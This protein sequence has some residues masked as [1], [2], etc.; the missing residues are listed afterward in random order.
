MKRRGQNNILPSVHYTDIYFTFETMECQGKIRKKVS[1]CSKKFHRQKVPLTIILPRD[2]IS[3]R[4][5]ATGN[6][7]NL[8]INAGM[9]ELGSDGSAACGGYSDLSEWQWSVCNAAAPSERRTPGTTTG[10]SW[11]NFTCLG[12]LVIEVTAYYEIATGA[13]HPRND[14]RFGSLIGHINNHLWVIFMI[15]KEAFYRLL[16]QKPLILDG[17]TGSNLQKA[18]MPRGCCTEQW[19]LEHPDALIAL[20]RRYVQSGSQVI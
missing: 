5:T 4:H 17:A 14:T 10:I 16:E 15:K 13:M 12:R 11:Y 7:V 1:A 9:V 20:Q 18:G 2:K 19:I 6:A 3:G 8:W